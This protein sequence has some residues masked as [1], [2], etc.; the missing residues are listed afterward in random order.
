MSRIGF[1]INPIAGMGGRVGLKG[2]DGV[3]ER[4]IELGARP[5]APRKAEEALR[6]LHELLDRSARR[7]DIQWITCAGAMGADALTRAGFSD[8]QVVY[9]PDNG[10]SSADTEAAVRRF[11]ERGAD[12]VLFCGGDGTARDVCAVA[13]EETPVLGIPSGVK[14]FSGVF[15][16]NPARTAE[17]LL[18]FLRGELTPTHVEVMDLDEDRYRRGEWAVRLYHS[19]LTPFE[20]TFTQSSKMLVAAG[21]DADAKEDIARYVIEQ[22]GANPKVLLLLGAG[23]TVKALGDQ[24]RIDK[25]LLGI[26]A[27][28]GGK[29]VARD[30]NEEQILRLLDQYPDR[31]LV[32]SPIGAQGFVLG[33]GNLQLSP[34]VI[35]RIG[36][37]NLIV[38]STPAKLSR[39]PVLR[40][41]TGDAALD[42]ELFDQGYLPVVT[43]YGQ[44]RVVKVAI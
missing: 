38:I 15:G 28:V 24:L 37:K 1:L 4:A 30:L 42:E 22:H 6:R 35:R 12:L 36:R 23:G 43:G 41:D 8:S 19:A 27:V 20:P 10:T 44:S 3:V 17:I 32:L 9:E 11:I 14:M 40:F 26:D 18:G 7:P 33:R 34:E 16:T 29:L 39:T 31:R 5:V 2:T 21:S 13:G 25:T